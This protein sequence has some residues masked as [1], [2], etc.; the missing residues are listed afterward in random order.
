M[1]V[2]SAV[3]RHRGAVL[4]LV[5]LASLGKE[6]IAPFV[7]ALVLICAR[8][9]DDA[10]LPPKRFTITA[11]A[12]GI[13]AVA[14]NAAFNV[15]RFG[16]VRNLLYLD[17]SFQTPGVVR[18]LDFLSAIFASPASGVLWYWPLFSVLALSAT[19]IGIHELCS[20]REKPRDYLPVLSVTG[21]MLV[22]FAGLSAWFSPF[23]GSPSVRVSRY[24]CWWA[25]RCLCLHG[26]RRDYY[27]SAAVATSAAFGC[28]AAS[29]RI[30]SVLCSLELVPGILQLIAGRGSCPDMTRLDIHGNTDQFYRC[31]HQFMWRIRPSVFDDVIQL[32]LAWSTSVGSSEWSRVSA[33]GSSSQRHERISIPHVRHARAQPFEQPPRDT[34]TR[35]PRSNVLLLADRAR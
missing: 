23:G 35:A 14:I 19:A 22:W 15:F 6:T 4:T 1:A 7:V 32:G 8:S 20:R 3:R 16:S 26:R 29:G 13:T 18:K 11:V 28:G 34:S 24:P 25:H 5:L 9:E 10:L 27:A 2:C 31:A 12:A 33:C 21:V 17:P 30:D